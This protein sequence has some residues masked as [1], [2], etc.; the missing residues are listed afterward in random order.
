VRLQQAAARADDGFVSGAVAR[1]KAV[2]CRLTDGCAEARVLLIVCIKSSA[3]SADAA[4]QEH[5]AEH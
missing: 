2:H 1:I 5:T 3:A 4:V